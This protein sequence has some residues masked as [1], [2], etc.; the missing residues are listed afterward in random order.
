M[1]PG[2]V[3]DR[4]VGPFALVRV[5]I[6]SEESDR[7]LGRIIG[8]SQ[9]DPNSSLASKFKDATAE[10]T[11]RLQDGLRDALPHIDTAELTLRVA[12]MMSAI[13]G[14]AS[15]TF[16]VFI[17]ESDPTRDLQDRVIDRLIAITTP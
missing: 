7:R 3:L 15:G 6:S 16:D 1:V 10:P 14:F 13:K 2:Q 17:A 5:A 12:L 4:V 9:A 8:Q 11:Q